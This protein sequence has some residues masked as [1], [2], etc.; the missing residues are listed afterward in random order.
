MFASFTSMGKTNCELLK[1][2]MNGWRIIFFVLYL[3]FGKKLIKNNCKTVTRESQ[4]K[5]LTLPF[6]FDRSCYDL[7]L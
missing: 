7:I 2:Y 3:N 5:Q 6:F 4:K 1:W